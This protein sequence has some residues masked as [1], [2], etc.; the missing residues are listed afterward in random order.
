MA[1]SSDLGGLRVCVCMTLVV[2]LTSVVSSVCVMTSVVI[3][4]SVVSSVCVMTSVVI[5][6]SVVL[7]VQLY[8]TS[9][10]IITDWLDSMVMYMHACTFSAC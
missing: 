6:T 1:K 9:V 5:L 8:R 7:L 3:L 2:I 10:V 4:T